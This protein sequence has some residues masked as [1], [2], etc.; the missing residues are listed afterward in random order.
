M[1]ALTFFIWMCD[2]KVVI[3]SLLHGQLFWLLTPFG[4]LSVSQQF[5]FLLS[6]LLSIPFGWVLHIFVLFFCCIHGLLCLWPFAN[7]PSSIALASS[8]QESIA[9]ACFNILSFLFVFLFN[10]LL[11][12]SWVL[13]AQM[14]NP[15]MGI[16]SRTLAK[17]LKPWNYSI[18]SLCLSQF[19]KIQRLPEIK[20]LK[21][22][23]D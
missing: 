23:L 22:L 6:F 7:D 1:N 18:C 4:F 21:G 8:S 11:S 12:Y 14:V 10:F 3:V 17:N 16:H 15:I 20:D 13:L 19:K 5:L 9:S 2:H